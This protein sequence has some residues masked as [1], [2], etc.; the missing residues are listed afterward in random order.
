VNDGPLLL[1]AKFEPL[2]V[3]PL[4]NDAGVFVQIVE[5]AP[6]FAVGPHPH[7]TVKQRKA[8]PVLQ[9]SLTTSFSW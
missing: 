6:A 9:P 7:C 3:A 1:S 8:C 2:E 5:V 4:L